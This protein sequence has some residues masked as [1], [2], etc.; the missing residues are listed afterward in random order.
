MKDIPNSIEARDIRS[1][2][3]PYT[4]ARK[5]QEIGPTV[6][7]RGEGVHVWDNNG[8]KYIE[9][10]S[11]LWSAGLGFS[12]KRLVAAA[13]KQLETLP[14][15]HIFSHRS[16]GP[17]VDLAEKLLQIAPVPM[18]K[19]FFTNSGSEANDTAVKLLW[20]RAHAMGKPEK[21]KV[22]SRLRGYHGVTIVAASMGSLKVSTTSSTAPVVSPVGLC[23]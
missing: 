3:H 16:H 17:A 21:K 4:D 11:G 9:A 14:F 19:V 20:F 10:M 7:E 8:K 22:I 18:S 23:W 6:I 2:M 5:H 12:E 15:Y 13:T 1:L